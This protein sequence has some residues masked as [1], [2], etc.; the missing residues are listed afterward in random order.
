LRFALDLD[1]YSLSLF[2]LNSLKN[3]TMKNLITRLQNYHLDF[4]NNFLTIE[5]FASHYEITQAEA[6]IILQAGRLL[7]KSKFK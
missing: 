2:I 6:K 1:I 4:F 3:K 5:K 7:N